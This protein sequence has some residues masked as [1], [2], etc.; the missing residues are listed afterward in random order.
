MA[1]KT[2]RKDL[3]AAP[4]VDDRFLAALSHELRTPLNGVLGMAD[5]LARTRL[6]A[7]Q[8]SYVKALQDSGEHLLGLVND[9]LDL[10]KLDA[11]GFQPH[12][13][14]TDLERLLQTTAELLSPRAHAKGLQIAWAADPDLPLVMADE[15]RLR[16]VLFN[17]AGNAVKYT[18]AGGVRLHARAVEEDAK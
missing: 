16:Q 7:N 5:L 12:P 8:R 2:S 17:L 10:A 6:D 14:P 18:V 1:R 13:V 15:G 9:V 3:Q 11:G 4:G